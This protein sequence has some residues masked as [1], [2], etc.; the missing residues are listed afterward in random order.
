MENTEKKWYTLKVQNNREKSVSEKLKQEMMRDFNEEL[1]VLIPTRIISTIKSGKVN[2]KEQVMYP[3][4]IFV[5]TPNV[6]K[7]KHFVKIINGLSGILK[8]ELGE[9]IQMRNSE[10]ERMTGIVEE[11][12]TIS[13]GI[14]I[15]DQDVKIKNGPFATFRGKIQ[16]IDYEKDK[17][18][19]EVFIFG[20]ST[21]V[22]LT[23]KDIE[24]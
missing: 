6:D 21:I 19:L 22:D 4:Y 23:I 24:P 3:G 12:K 10:I 18:R 15:L 5:E 20:R 11:N 14:F 8:D 9:P 16:S 1:N 2:Q 17:V 13:H 7:V